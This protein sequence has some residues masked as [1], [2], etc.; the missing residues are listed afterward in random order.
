MPFLPDY[1]YETATNQLRGF[2]LSTKENE[3]GGQTT[4]FTCI[5]IFSRWPGLTYK[6]KLKALDLLL[7]SWRRP[8]RN[9]MEL[10]LSLWRKFITNG[11]VFTMQHS[12]LRGNT[13]LDKPKA[14]FLSFFIHLHNL[15]YQ[16]SQ[17]PCCYEAHLTTLGASTLTPKLVIVRG[18]S[19]FL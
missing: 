16:E 8:N 6:I 13:G 9:R 7:L 15:H 5:K 4:T 17:R 11:P 3:L 18:W 14:L 1:Q 2:A 19:S 12:V 10:F